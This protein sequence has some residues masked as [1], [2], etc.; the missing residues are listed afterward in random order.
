MA[1]IIE[2]NNRQFFLLLIFFFY[3]YF[4]YLFLERGEEKEGQRERNINV[5]SPPMHPLPPPGTRPAIQAYTPTGNQ[6]GD[7]LVPGSRSI[8]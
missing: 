4:I 6:T 7:P 8:H 2:C 1:I 3:I 5:W